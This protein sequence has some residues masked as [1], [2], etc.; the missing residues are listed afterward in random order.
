[1]FIK[2]LKMYIDH[3]KSL[4]NEKKPKKY[5]KE[6]WENLN[7]DIEYYKT[8]F[9]SKKHKFSENIKEK[10][11]SKLEEITLQLDEIMKKIQIIPA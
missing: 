6:F 2:E 3:L 11:L 8:L 10:S 9:S 5:L 1:M 4:L 7:N